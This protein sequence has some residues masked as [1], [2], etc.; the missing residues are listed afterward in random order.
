[1]KVQVKQGVGTVRINGVDHTEGE[2]FEMDKK[3]FKGL[4]EA[5]LVEKSTGE[6]TPEEA[7][8]TP[9]ATVPAADEGEEANAAD[10]EDAE[11]GEAEDADDGLGEGMEDEAPAAEVPAPEAPQDPDVEAESVNADEAPTETADAEGPAD[12]EVEIDLE[13]FGKLNR[14][15]MIEFLEKLAA[16][17]VELPEYNKEEITKKQLI[18]L[19]TSITE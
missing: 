13:A 14:G 18:E 2:T 12:D 16:S 6:V 5:D 3:T 8:E 15:P 1:M 9:V 4:E 7:P 11:D 10:A 19:L 17:G